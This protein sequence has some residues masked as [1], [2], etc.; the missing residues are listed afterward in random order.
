M[1]RDDERAEYKRLHGQL[2]ALDADIK[3]ARQDLQRATTA[4]FEEFFQGPRLRKPEPVEGD[5]F[6]LRGGATVVIRPVQ[7]ADS[8]LLKEGFHNLSAVS[9]YRRFLFDR[10]DPTDAE[11]RE[12]TRLD[13]RNHEAIVAVDQKD[14]AGAG[15]ARYVRDDVDRSRAVVAVT[16]VDSWQGRGLGTELFRRLT[17]RAR[18]EGIDHFEAHMIVGDDQARRMFERAGRLETSARSAGTLDVTVNLAG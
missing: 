5:E 13:H 9:R 10:P 8:S 12:L 14:G 16:V 7:P 4:H 3:M 17:A 15:I 2:D 11:A 6:R 1:R 18:A